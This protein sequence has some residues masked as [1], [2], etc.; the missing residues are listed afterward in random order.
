MYLFFAMKI[1]HSTTQ[2]TDEDSASNSS[3]ML[4][5]SHLVDNGH[6]VLWRGLPQVFIRKPVGVTQHW[7]LVV[8]EVHW[9][10]MQ[11][12]VGGVKRVI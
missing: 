8:G 9:V 7:L 1:G 2:V 12:M 4:R 10:V 3:W 5:L 6:R 11:N